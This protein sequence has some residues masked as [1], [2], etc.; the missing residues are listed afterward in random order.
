MTWSILEMPCDSCRDIAQNRRCCWPAT[1]WIVCSARL[2]R[3]S[4]PSAC[5]LS[6]I[7]ACERSLQ[8]WHLQAETLTLAD[9]FSVRREAARPLL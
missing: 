4:A 1:C 3:C 2:Y 7:Q 8:A 6:C 9:A 5:T